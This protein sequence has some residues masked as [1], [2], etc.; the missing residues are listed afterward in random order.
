MQLLPVFT[1]AIQVAVAPHTRFCGFDGVRE[2]VFDAYKVLDLAE[3]LHR[4]YSTDAHLV[5][6]VVRGATRH[7]DRR[8]HL[9]AT[10]GIDT[11]IMGAGIDLETRLEIVRRTFEASETTTVHM[12]DRASGRHGM[13][14]FVNA[15]LRGLTTDSD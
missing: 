2:N 5:S 10:H 15:V 14:P 8:L 4:H 11:V 1:P 6:Y 12:K 13:M 9:L 7:D 3:A